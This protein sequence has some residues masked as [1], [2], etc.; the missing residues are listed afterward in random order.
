M[1]N[2]FTKFIAATIFLF[3]FVGLKAQSTF[4]FD[5]AVYSSPGYGLTGVGTYY[6]STSGGTTTLSTAYNCDGN[7]NSVSTSSSTFYFKPDINITAINIKGKGTGNNRTFT[8]ISTSSTLAGT[9]TAISNG[10]V[11]NNMATSS[12]CGNILIP[13]ISVNSGTYIKVVLSGNV[14][15]T[16]IVL[17]PLCT[18]PTYSTQPTDNQTQCIGGTNSLTVAADQSP[19]YQWYSNTNKSNTGGTVVSTGTGGTTAT[20]TPASDVAG[21]FYFYCIAASSACTTASNAVVFTVNAATA[22]TGQSTATATYGQNASASALT[23]TA[24]GSGLSYQWYRSN[25]ASNATAGDDVTVGTNSNSYSPS[26]ATIGTSYYYCVVTGGC[27]PTTATSTVSGAIIITA[28]VPTISLT[29]GSNPASTTYG[30]ALSSVVYTYVNVADDN[31]VSGAWYTDGTYTITTTA[32]SGLSI[33]KNSPSKTMTLSGTPLSIGTFYYKVIVNET[34]GN[35]ISASVVVAAPPA[36]TISLTSGSATQAIIPGNAITN[37]VYTLTNATGASVTSLPTGLSGNYSS[38][39]YTISG[40]LDAGVTAGSYPFTVT[41]TALAG[42]SGTPV[43]ANGSIVAKS[44]TA[45]NVLYLAT[46][47]T[48]T[49][50]DLFLAQLT[51]SVNYIVTKRAAQASFVGNYNGIDLI[52]LH[53]SLTGGDAATAGHELNLIKSV[54]KPILNLKSYFYSTGRWSWGT[55]NNGNNGKGIKITQ[56][57]HPIFSGITITDS[58]YIYGSYRAKNIQPTTITIGGTQ[59]GKMAGGVAIHDV[60]ASVRLTSGTSKY[61]MISLLSGAYNDLTVDALKLLDNA[62]SYLLTGTQFV[63]VSLEISSFTVNGL[64]ATID[65]VANTIT[66]Q[67]S[68]VNLDH[69]IPTITLAAVS[70]TTVDPASGVEMNFYGQSHNYTVSDGTNTKIYAVTISGTW[71]GLST[72][73]IPGVSFNGQTIQNKANLHLQVFDTLGRLV[74]SSNKNISMSSYNKGVYIVKSGNEKLKIIVTK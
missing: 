57:T 42:Y 10:T 72:T 6:K 14:N 20:F 30:V 2:H 33:D 52:V 40:T 64:P 67:T 44:L 9:Y 5:A 21:I 25:D 13:G 46:D 50:N 18:A 47:A 38:G 22:I 63:P 73:S 16:S 3:G 56:P 7:T 17:T 62:V 58:V 45:K 54:D 60:P 70:G 48:T 43:T 8:S 26:T 66:L 1:K 29:S 71:T 15:I 27:A 32:P 11:T 34:N 19:T 68:D 61:L 23:V 51:N 55:P 69:V 49:S 37:I 35:S 53:E 31:N 28:P 12:T 41:A 24:V 36:P 39:T 74:E 59:I 65:N 4:S